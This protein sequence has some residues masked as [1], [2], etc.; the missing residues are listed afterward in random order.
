MT[1]F[2]IADDLTGALDTAVQFSKRGA[3][4]HVCLGGTLRS[5]S[6]TPD[7]DVLVVDAELRHRSAGDAL[8]ETA[9]LATL[10][11]EA[12]IPNLYIKTDSGLRG[13]IGPAL[14]GA[15]NAYE[16]NYLAFVPAYPDMNRITLCGEQLAN[17]KPVHLSAF[18]EDFFEPV[19]SSQVASLLNGYPVQTALI[20]RN[21]HYAPDASLRHVGIYDAQSNEDLAFIAHDLKAVN[22]LT[23]TAGC[24][25]FASAL[26]TA[27]GLDRGETTPPQYHAPLLVICG[28]LHPISRAQI[29]QGMKAGFRHIGVNANL[30]SLDDCWQTAQGQ[31]ILN[32]FNTFFSESRTLLV[33]SISTLT[34]SPDSA[35]ADRFPIATSFGR[36]MTWLLDHGAAKHFTPMMIG[37]DTLMGFFRANPDMVIDLKG[38]IAQGVVLI[39]VHYRGQQIPM[40]TKSGGFGDDKLLVDLDMRGLQE[41]ACLWKS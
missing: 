19:R 2:I 20:P 15:M 1:I 23:V 7:V 38:E 3:C 34:E 24:A 10:S 22:R 5:I 13:N 35:D 12:G 29:A 21:E 18:G 17:G 11:R 14:I 4:V 32:K 31:H 9:R 41:E 33:S 25:G 30:L 37:G 27:L 26:C 36:L 39:N 8:E 40:I 28:S 6:N 16:V